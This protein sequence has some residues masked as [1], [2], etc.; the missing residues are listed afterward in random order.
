MSLALWLHP[1]NLAD[2]G[3]AIVARVHRAWSGSLGLPGDAGAFSEAGIDRT[4]NGRA[5]TA[6]PRC[7]HT[8]W[9]RDLAFSAVALERLGGRHRER[10]VASLAWALAGWERHGSHITTTFHPGGYPA[11]VY[12]YGVD[13]LPFFLAALRA[14][15]TEGDVL[16][17][18]HR[19]WLPG[20]GPPTGGATAIPPRSA[21]RPT[22][23]RRPRSGSSATSCPITRAAPSGPASGRSTSSCCARSI[24]SEPP[25][26]PPA[27][28]P[29]S[30]A[31][32]PSGRSSARPATAGAV[33]AA[34][35]SARSRCCGAPSSWTTC[36]HRWRLPRA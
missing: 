13:S 28:P 12:E 32:G 7:F 33:V 23:H 11:D 19:E 36:A 31:T 29:G 21:T 25:A 17:A 8:F 4:W 15:G 16:V 10:L 22:R 30:S 26:T 1:A 3:R 34:S 27:M 9:V 24:P 18:A 2:C 6:S 20:G 14:V 5:F 35:W